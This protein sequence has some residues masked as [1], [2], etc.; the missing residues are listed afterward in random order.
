M[1]PKDQQLHWC[2]FGVPISSGHHPAGE[3]VPGIL[4]GDGDLAA[5]IP[6]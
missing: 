6:R 4:H 3:R 1:Q 5:L 2:L